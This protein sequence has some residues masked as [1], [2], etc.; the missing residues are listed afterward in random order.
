MEFKNFKKDVEA[1]FNNMIAENLFVANVDKD[2]LWMGYLLSFE[3]ET[4][5]QD[6]NC[7][8]CKSFIRHYGKVVAIDPQTYK[9]KTFWDDVHTP[10][11]EKTAQALAKLVKEAGIGDV[12]IQ[13]VN[14]FHGCDHNVQLLPD[15][16]TRTWTHLYVTIPN[17]FKFNRRVHGFDSA[18][19]YRGD[20]RARA[21]VFERSIS[22]LKLEAV[23]TVIE[24]IEGNNLYRGAEFLKSLEEFRRT[25]VTAQTLSPEVGTNY[26]WL[27][28]KSPIAKIRNTAMGT[29]L[30]DLSNGVDLEKACPKMKSNGDL[31]NLGKHVV[32][33]TVSPQILDRLRE[34]GLTVCIC[35]EFE[36]VAWL[37]FSPGLPFDIHGEGYDFEELGLIGTEANLRYFEKVTPNYIDCGTDVDKFINTCLQFK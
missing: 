3:D 24:L 9:I 27:N 13:D 12:F 8:A 35:C 4:V 18:A 31:P 37:T 17:N 10:G 33:K 16:T 5:R 36:G 23:E 14:E 11:Y 6:H 7:N 15:G 22:E 2:L 34:S 19:G 20:V 25:L 28:F 1:A 29:L 32:L 21:G 26:C 30:I